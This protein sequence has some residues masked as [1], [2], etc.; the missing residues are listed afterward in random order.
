MI[1][2]LYL[3]AKH[4]KKRVYKLFVFL[5]NYKS[6]I[7]CETYYPEKQLKNKLVIFTDFVLHII[8]TGEIDHSYFELGLDVK[9]NSYKTFLSYNQFMVRRDKLNLTTPYNYVCLM[10]DKSLFNSLCNV[11]GFPTINELG[12]IKDGILYDTKYNSIIEILYANKSLF[13]K[14]L[15]SKKG[16]DIHKIEYINDN[17]YINNDNKS[18]NE[19]EVYIKELSCKNNFLI[20]KKIIQHPHISTIYEKSINT[21]RVVTINN[22]K[23]HDPNDI[24]VLGVELRVGANGNFTDNISAG[25]VKIGVD[26]SGCLCKYG[27]FNHKFGTK[28]LIHPD[29]QTVFEGY[30][31]PYYSDAV[32]LCKKF[33]S[34]I[35]GIHLIGWDV[36]ITVDGPIFI[37]G[38]DSCGT[39]FQVL[40]GPM[41]HVYDKYLPEL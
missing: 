35:Q 7:N 19:L 13:I 3:F 31:I 10:R 26:E 6:Y 12:K 20:Q 39:D 32:E 29:T 9:G 36:A 22:L 34:K 16:Q 18:I 28:S 25:G 30:S 15:D 40:Y 2:R 5:C 11:W 4:I 14:P 33:H 17:V 41:K 24:Y 38:N 8:K 23:S 27:Y 37:E 21:L 1:K